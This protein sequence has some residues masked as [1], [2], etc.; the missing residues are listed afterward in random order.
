MSY[1]KYPNQ[2]DDSTSVVISQDNV[3]QVKAEIVNRLRDA[4]LAVENELGTNPS[5]TY[6]TVKDRLDALDSTIAQFRQITLSQDLDG[7][8][9]TPLV[10]G[11]RGRPLSTVSPILGNVYM[12][13][14]V[15]WTPTLINGA[16]T[17]V[18]GPQGATGPTGSIGPQGPDGP[19]GIVGPTGPT[20][21]AGS[22]GFYWSTRISWCNWSTRRTRLPRTYRY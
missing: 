1:T 9:E 21:P 7:T 11:L 14:G 20:G 17:G 4:L 8:L 5:S 16:V 13:D 10:V 19:Q 12:W 18:A 22:I 6:N 15:D 2:I 3:T